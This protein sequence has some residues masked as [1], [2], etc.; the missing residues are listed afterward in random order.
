MVI[1]FEE[2]F[3]EKKASGIFNAALKRK[4]LIFDEN[5]TIIGL[6]SKLYSYLNL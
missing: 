1:F 4:L 6:L 2:F 3:E 5:T